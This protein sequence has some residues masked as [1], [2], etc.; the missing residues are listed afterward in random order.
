MFKMLGNL[1]KATVSVALTP[2]AAA[3]DVVMIIPDSC[4]GDREMFSRTGGLMKNAGECIEESLKPDK[5]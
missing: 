2:V 3:V 1:A 4:D 5:E